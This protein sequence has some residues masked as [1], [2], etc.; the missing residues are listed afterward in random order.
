MDL[1]WK[2]GRWHTHFS[3]RFL[4]LDLHGL[5]AQRVGRVQ[6]ASRFVRGAYPNVC[7]GSLAWVLSSSAKSE[8]MK[9]AGFTLESA[10]DFGGLQWACLVQR[11][12]LPLGGMEPR[13]SA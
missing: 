8:G 3:L 7:T 9:Q 13:V 4:L 1:T 10:R 12:H 11:G 2:I 6:N 5:V